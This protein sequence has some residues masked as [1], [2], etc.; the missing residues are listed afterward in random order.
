MKTF[1]C[2]VKI[3]N[4]IHALDVHRSHS[5]RG[6]SGYDR[7]Y[8]MKVFPFSLTPHSTVEKNTVRTIEAW[9]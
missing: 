7:G 2:E 4:A 3:V 6:K 1:L 8:K 9:C 5:G